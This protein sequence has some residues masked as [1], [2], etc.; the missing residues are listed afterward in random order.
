[1]DI[2]QGKDKDRKLI[3]SPYIEIQDILMQPLKPLVHLIGFQQTH[4]VIIQI[5]NEAI[6]Q[7]PKN[8]KNFNIQSYE[9]YDQNKYK[10]Q[11]IYDNPYKNDKTKNLELGYLKFS[12][13]KSLILYKP[14]GTIIVFD[15][16]NQDSLGYDWKTYEA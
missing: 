1:M 6:Q 2:V 5:I 13:F 3:Y 4:P 7:N 10:D 12:F 14:A 16:Q 11:L 9:F 15:W 8:F